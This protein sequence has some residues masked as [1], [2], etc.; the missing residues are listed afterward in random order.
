M[1][2]SF[3]NDVQTN[4]LHSTSTNS[5]R[6]ST[7][8]GFRLST[9]GYQVDHSITDAISEFPKPSNR[10]ELHSFYG[11]V[12]QLSSSTSD[13]ASLLTPLRPLLSIKNDFIWLGDHDHAFKAAK[14]SLTVAPIL[15]YFD[16]T[17][18]S[19]LCTDASRHGLGFIL[20]QRP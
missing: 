8:A 6:P 14:D 11:L 16:A 5:A 1:S 7:F 15:S 13:V 19:R 18:P 9:Q 3:Y 2:C 4:T 10:T 17:R 12:N 20:Q